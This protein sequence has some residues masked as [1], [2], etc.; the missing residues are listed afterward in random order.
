M[1]SKGMTRTQEGLKHF[2]DLTERAA[3]LG[4]IGTQVGLQDEGNT[5]DFVFCEEV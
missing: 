3:H 1:L 4:S 2:G 5:V